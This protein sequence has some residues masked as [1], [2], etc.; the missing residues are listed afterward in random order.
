MTS[1]L[2]TVTKIY[3]CLVVD[4]YDQNKIALAISIQLIATNGLFRSPILAHF[5][6]IPNTL[7]N[8]I[9]GLIKMGYL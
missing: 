5:Q 4:N 8:K 3:R 2:I 9:K 6:N 7:Q 1:K